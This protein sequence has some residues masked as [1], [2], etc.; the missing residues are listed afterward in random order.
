MR[1]IE[2]SSDSIKR[3]TFLIIKIPEGE[4][5]GVQRTFENIMAGNFLN[6][7]KETCIQ[8]QKTQSPKHDQPK[9]ITPRQVTL[10]VAKFRDKERILKAAGES[11]KLYTKGT[12]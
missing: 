8:V 7:G 10:K 4:K 6:Q 11:N 5:R 12:P 9:K 1:K 3:P 2:R